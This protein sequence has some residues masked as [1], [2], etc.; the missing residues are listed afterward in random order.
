MPPLGACTSPTDGK[1][2]QNSLEEISA[3]VFGL[4]HFKPFSDSRWITVGSNSR[5]LIAAELSGLRSLVGYIRER[6]SDFH[7][8]GYDD[9]DQ[10][11]MHCV[12]KSALASYTSDAALSLLLKDCRVP[13]MADKLHDGIKKQLEWLENSGM[14]LFTTLASL[15]DPSEAMTGPRLYSEVVSCAHTSAGFFHWRCLRFVK[16]THG[17]SQSGTSRRTLTSL[18]LGLSLPRV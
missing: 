16:G 15:F 17:S 4:W 1:G 13:L 7:I 6:D 8:K 10:E 9:F 5:T 2:T 18:Q 12:V 11:V 3:A 14:E